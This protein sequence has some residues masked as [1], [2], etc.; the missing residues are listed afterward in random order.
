MKIMASV[1]MLAACASDEIPDIPKLSPVGDVSPVLNALGET[2]FA[3]L[4][5]NSYW[6][7]GFYQSFLEYLHVNL[8][9]PWWAAI[10]TSMNSKTA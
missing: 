10:A 3:S 6:P 8:D 2:T 9:L 7:S 5:L 1:P 4:G